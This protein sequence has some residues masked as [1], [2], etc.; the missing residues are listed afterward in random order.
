LERSLAE[1]KAREERETATRINH[2]QSDAIKAL[3]E[4]MEAL[5]AQLPHIIERAIAAH[6]ARKRGGF[7]GGFLGPRGGEQAAAAVQ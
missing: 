1:D 3:H 7:F 2:E 6:H 5:E 4:R